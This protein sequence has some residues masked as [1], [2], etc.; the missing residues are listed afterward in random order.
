MQEPGSIGEARMEWIGVDLDETLATVDASDPDVVGPPIPAM[1]Q[2]VKRWWQEGRGV[3]IVTAR[4]ARPSFDKLFHRAEKTQIEQW[5]VTHLG[6]VLPIQAHKDYSMIEL[7]DDRV[8]QVEPNTVRPI[9]LSRVSVEAPDPLV[10]A[11]VS[12]L[13]AWIR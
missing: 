10:A 5:C 7:W 13:A 6:Q 3:R 2:R 11:D 1:V 12:S 9:G 4:A 8:V